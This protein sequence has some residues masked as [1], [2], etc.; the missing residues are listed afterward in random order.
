MF[1]DKEKIIMHE[2]Q[3]LKKNKSV[4]KDESF[5]AERPRKAAIQQKAKMKELA[6]KKTARQESKKVKVGLFSVPVD[7]CFSY[8]VSVL[9][10]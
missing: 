10:C 3:S 8:A 7:M 6:G 9:T 2:I 4:K 5:H 1:L